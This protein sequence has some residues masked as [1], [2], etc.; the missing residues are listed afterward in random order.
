MVDVAIREARNEEHPFIYA[1][2][3]RGYR[4]SRFADR[5]PASVYFAAHHQVVERLLARSRVLVATPAGDDSTVLGYSVVEGATVHF[6]YIKL[7]FRKL[8]IARRLLDGVDVPHCSAS[9]V[10]KDAEEAMRRWPCIVYNPYL[11]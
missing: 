1:T 9:H 2:W 4:Q 7:A 8:G 3:L 5:V 6:V 10:T 11:I